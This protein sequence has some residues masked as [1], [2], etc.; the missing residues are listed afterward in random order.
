MSK[1]T[2]PNLKIAIL[3]WGSLISKPEGDA[4]IRQ[5]PL[6]ITGGFVPGGPRL[7]IEFSR[8]SQDGRLTLVIDPMHGTPCDTFY[9]I[10]SM[11]DL[12]AAIQNLAEREGTLIKHIHSVSRGETCSDEIRSR[13]AAWLIEKG[14]DA[15]VWTGLPPK[16]QFQGFA[17]FST[18]AA[19]AYLKSLT[20][21]V[22]N[23]AFNYINTAPPTV[24]TP[25]R[26]AAVTLMRRLES[27]SS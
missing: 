5:K 13:I 10:S 4:S 8:I 3:G 27:Y 25:V 6:R 19:I 9:T 20:G 17:G 16:F 21:E 26:E 11:P 1:H 22:R 23:K 12:P 18:E 15:A 24:K 14:F 2:S 7:P